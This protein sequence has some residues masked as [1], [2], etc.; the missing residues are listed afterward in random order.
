MRYW[1][2][3]SEP[4]VFGI[5]HLARAPRQTSGWDGVRESLGVAHK[6]ADRFD[7]AALQPRPELASTHYCL[8]DPGREY[9][10]LVPWD[11]GWKRSLLERLIPGSES[12]AADV[13]LSAAHGPLDVEWI[14]LAH[15]TRQPGAPVTG[16][17]HLAFRAPATRDFILHL[18][19]RAPAAAASLN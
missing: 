9:L 14:D 17:G 8:A 1:L 4:D 15:G 3:K 13:D 2:M 11:G 6:L 5:D 19:T 10:V 12:V 18:E 16:G 7:L